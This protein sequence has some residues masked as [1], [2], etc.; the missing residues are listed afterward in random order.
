MVGRDGRGRKGGGGG[1]TGWGAE[2]GGIGGRAVEVS[3]FLCPESWSMVAY[4]RHNCNFVEI[5]I[6]FT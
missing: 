3:V 5:T 1:G 4:Q 6:M 2:G